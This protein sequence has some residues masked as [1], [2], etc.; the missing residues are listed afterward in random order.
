MTAP[1]PAGAQAYWLEFVADYPQARELIAFRNAAL[2]EEI[3]GLVA[4]VTT[5][6]EGDAAQGFPG[7]SEALAALA[8]RY[9]LGVTLVTASARN[10]IAVRPEFDPDAFDSEDS[11]GEI[12]ITFGEMRDLI[13]QGGAAAA[14]E[15]QT[16]YLDWIQYPLSFK[17]GGPLTRADVALTNAVNNYV[18]E[19][20]EV[21]TKALRDQIN[22]A[23]QIFVGQ[24]WGDP[25]LV[26]YM[27]DI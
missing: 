10:S 3:D 9:N 15:L 17:T 25:A 8:P 7:A 13:D 26:E 2:A 6:F 12:L 23:E 20:T 4:A 19:Q 16:L 11:L 1:D 21:T 22:V 18:A 14:G 24:Y 5:A 27:S